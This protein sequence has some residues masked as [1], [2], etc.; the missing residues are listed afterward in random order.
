[1]EQL[2]T[3][4]FGGGPPNS[5]EATCLHTIP[6]FHA[7][8]APLSH[9]T[10]EGAGGKCVQVGLFRGRFSSFHW[11][12]QRA[13][14]PRDTGCPPLPPPRLSPPPPRPATARE[15]LR[16]RRGSR[17]LLDFP[18]SAAIAR[19]RNPDPAPSAPSRRTRRRTRGWELGAGGWGLRAGGCGL[20]ACLRGGS[21]GAAG[22]APPPL[23]GPRRRWGA[24]RVTRLGRPPTPAD[25][26]PSGSIPPSPPTGKLR[27]S[28]IRSLWLQRRAE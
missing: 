7:C 12:F 26:V 13:K 25:I 23:A 27:P 22:A 8:I 6:S 21:E 15:P 5:S 4:A 2:K 20:R 28:L 10:W 14:S 1:M 24:L 9:S 3:S 16:S 19:N 18:V 11:N 17:K